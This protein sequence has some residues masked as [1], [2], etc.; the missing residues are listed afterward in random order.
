[1]LCFITGFQTSAQSTDDLLQRLKLN[2]A[3]YPPQDILSTKSLVLLSV[4]EDS[5]IS[6]WQILADELQTFFAEVG[7]D[8][9]VWLDARKY[10]IQQQIVEEVPETILKR[11]P[12]NLILFQVKN[13]EAPVFV[14]MGPF[15]GKTS[16]WNKGD[17]FWA[18]QSVNLEGI[19]NE[20]SILFRTDQFYRDNLLV[21][22][23][24]EFFYPEFD[25]GLT[26]KSIPPIISRY[27]TYVEPFDLSYPEQCGFPIFTFESFN[28]L[29]EVKSG[30]Q[31]R[32][33]RIEGIATDT[34][35]NIF[36]RDYSRNIQQLRR[37]GF[38][39]ALKYVKGSEIELYKMM[40][41]DGRSKPTERIMYKF[42]LEN[43]RNNNNY[44][45]MQW[46]AH[47]DWDTAL[48]NFLSQMD[49]ARQKVPIN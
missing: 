44:V 36:S 5:Q 9:I 43:L 1:M 28:N 35:N 20:L 38:Q 2:Q 47:E 7:I 15:N 45:G 30:L 23:S 10:Q 32:N 41:Y 14:A 48:S 17:S 12:K 31:E 46:D 3:L 49:E 18:R 29:D 13:K 8:A 22:E 39:Y 26:A 21:N 40:P 11:Q 6:E 16:L 33:Y 24:P 42:F 4:P 19:T 37:D 34:I 27:K 25:F